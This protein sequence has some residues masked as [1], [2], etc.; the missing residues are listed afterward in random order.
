MKTQMMLYYMTMEDLN[1]MVCGIYILLF[2][3]TD[4]TSVLLK[5]IGYIRFLQSQIEAL[6][7]P[8]LSNGSGNTRHQ[9]HS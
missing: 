5:A 9:Q 1:F 3:Q 4:T 8:Y 7:L 6:S 2:L